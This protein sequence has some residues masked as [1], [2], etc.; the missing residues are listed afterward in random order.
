MKIHGLA[1]IIIS[2]IGFCRS[3]DSFCQNEEVQFMANIEFIKGHL[4][5]AVAN[6]QGNDTSLAFADRLDI[7]NIGQYRIKKKS[8][9][10]V[11]NACLF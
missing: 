2:A 11:T 6:K 10:L 5:Y 9:I 4:E 1:S 7:Y 3:G 8:A